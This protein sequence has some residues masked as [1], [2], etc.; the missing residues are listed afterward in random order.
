MMPVVMPTYGQRTPAMARGEGAYLWDTDGRRYVD[1]GAG[2]AVCNLGH[3]HPHLVAELQKQAATL[4]HVSNHY[5]IPGQE[6][7]AG[8]LVERTFADT[9]FFSNSGVEAWEGGIKVCRKYHSAT[10]NPKRWRVITVGGAFH[11]RTL[12][13]I[14]AVK[15]AKL[16]DGFGPLVD[17]FDQ[18]AFGNMNEMRAAITD[19]TAAICIEPI[20]GEGGIKPADIEYLKA[21]RAVCD[22]FGLLLYFDEIQTGFGRTGKLFAHE[23]AG[24]TPD[25]MCTAKGIGGGFPLGAFMATEKAAVGMVAGTHGSTFGGNPLAMAVGNAVLD[26]MLEEGFLDGVTETAAL[27]RPQLEALAARYPGVFEEV[28]GTGLMLGLRLNPAITNT[29][30]ITRLKKEHLLVLPAGENVLRLLP[31]LVITPVEI[32]LALTALETVSAAIS[33]ELAA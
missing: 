13:A 20:I 31:P 1:F 26:V 22:E 21:L 27:L 24:I 28:R 2:V 17:G 10:G 23:W 12:A 33:Q 32:D 25:V 19:E 16:T 29:D 4:W 5:A 18:V 11:G 14:S 9:V 8:R 30:F 6:K 15:S 3:C 7:L